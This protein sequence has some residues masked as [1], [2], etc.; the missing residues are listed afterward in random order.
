MAGERSLFV[1]FL[2]AGAAAPACSASDGQGIP[3]GQVAVGGQPAVSGIGGAQEG[4]T[5][6]LGGSSGVT[7]DPAALAIGDISGLWMVTVTSVTKAPR[8]MTVIVSSGAITVEHWSGF[9]QAVAD[10]NLS[11]FEAYHETTTRWDLLLARHMSNVEMQL[12]ALPFDL[13][14]RWRLGNLVETGSACEST[15]KPLEF[16]AHCNDVRAPGW[17]GDLADGRISGTKRVELASMFGQLGGQ[18]ELVF[19][20]GGSC[21]AHIEHTTLG[22]TCQGTGRL[23]GASMITIN[24]NTA[25]GFTSRGIEFSAVRG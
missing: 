12:G 22:I 13:A 10:N 20:R 11:S 15:L 3:G 24:G 16:D 18:W 6:A 8:T 19:S 14:G 2:A 1:F 25:S 17:I 9:V 5:G 7:V 4:T 21:T 23:D